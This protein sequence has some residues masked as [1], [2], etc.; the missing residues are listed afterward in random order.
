MTDTIVSLTVT[1]RFDA[2]PE[3]VFDAW[4]NPH[5]ARAWLFTKPDSEIERCEID[6]RVGGSFVFVDKR[7]SGHVI[8]RG[9]YLEIDPPR[10]LQFRFWMDD[11]PDGVDLLSVEIT[12]DGA[13]CIL[14]LTHE[15]HPDWAAYEDYSRKAWEAM[16]AVL[17]GELGGAPGAD[18]RETVITRL[19]DAPRTLVW[20][21]WIDPNQL[22]HWW[23][24][25]DFTNPR[26]EIDVQP[27][28]AI[29]I[30]MRG[31]D[32]TVYPMNGVYHDVAPPERL[33]FTSAALDGEGA[34]LFHLRHAVAFAEQDGRTRVTVSTKVVALYS[35]IAADYLKGMEQGWTQSL[36]RL[37]TFVTVGTDAD[38]T[39]TLTRVIDAPRA[40]VWRAWT[41]A[42]HL[43]QWFFP[44]GCTIMDPNFDVSE[45]G[46][47]RCWYRGEDGAAHRLQGRFLELA[48]PERLVLTHGWENADGV[49]ENDTR[50]VVTLAEEGRRTRLT[51]HQA[52]FDTV[53][54]RDS[55]AEGWGQ[56]LDHLAAHLATAGDTGTVPTERGEAASA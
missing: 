36:E 20:H 28:G 11:Q 33:V 35:A 39:L 5:A 56:A 8:H 26:C 30:D 40:L 53:A 41:N 7:S 22:K 10:R 21:A 16:L 34:P 13:G 43:R 29:R 18:D 50:V 54:T 25:A 6:P 27:G 9:T 23:G 24:P 38:R 19:V 31:P 4:L 45:G 37:D 52:T 44:A 47:Y 48:E 15:L 17:A 2:S 32:G 14:A 3:Q 1:R 42:E 55:H 12:P 49:V 46:A 51:V